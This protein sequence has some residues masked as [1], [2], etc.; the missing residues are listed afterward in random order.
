MFTT[1]IVDKMS[2]ICGRKTNR[3]R[4][5]KISYLAPVAQCIGNGEENCPFPLWFRHLARGWPSHGRR[6]HAPKNW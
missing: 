5:S 2:K 1:E 4:H 6:K 3:T